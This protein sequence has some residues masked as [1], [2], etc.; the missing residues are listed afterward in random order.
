MTENDLLDFVKKRKKGR[1]R[2]FLQNKTKQTNKKTNHQKSMVWSQ[3]IPEEV[4]EVV[5]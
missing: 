1:L 3:L 2:Q 5:L 4:L